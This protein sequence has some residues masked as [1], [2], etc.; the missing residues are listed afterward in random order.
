[1]TNG[2]D[3]AFSRP[4][5][6]DEQL[7]HQFDYGAFGLTKREYFAAMALSGF[8]S[9]EGSQ[10]RDFRGKIAQEAVEMADAL[11]EALNESPGAKK[12]E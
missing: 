4:A 12:N 2:N 8:C 3:A 10:V 6:P 5:L 9:K 7:N 1:M 11:I